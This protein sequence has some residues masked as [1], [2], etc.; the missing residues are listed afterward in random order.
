MRFDFRVSTD[1]AITPI[2]ATTMN[3]PGQR[4]KIKALARRM[5]KCRIIPFIA[6]TFFLV[7]VLFL[8]SRIS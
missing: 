5:I 3:P 2:A 6:R 1:P 8:L 7:A 4:M